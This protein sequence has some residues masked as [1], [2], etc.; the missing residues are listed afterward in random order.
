MTFH[1]PPQE[2]GLQSAGTRVGPGMSLR[3]KA[4]APMRFRAPEQVRKEQDAS[5]EPESRCID[6]QALTTFR[7]MPH[8]Q[9]R[10][11]REAFHEP[12]LSSGA[13]WPKGSI[14]VSP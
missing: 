9:F 13:C 10:K 1:E 2:R 4:R 8:E 5:H 3:A 12:F 6:L 11:E 14:C 7:F